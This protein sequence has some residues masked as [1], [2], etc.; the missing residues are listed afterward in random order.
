[1]SKTLNIFLLYIEKILITGSGCCGTTFL[2]KLFSFLIQDTIE[3]I[4]NQVFLLIVI[5]VWKEAI[6]IIIIS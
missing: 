2:I 4:I 6:Q 3:T 1:M 5:L